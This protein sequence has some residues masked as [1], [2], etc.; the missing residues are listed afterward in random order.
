MRL[1]VIHT[2]QNKEAA[3]VAKAVAYFFTTRADGSSHYVVDDLEVYQCVDDWHE[4]CGAPGANHDGIHVEHAGMAGQTPEEWM[5][6]YSQA[7]LRNS[8]DLVRALCEIYEIP[9]VRLTVEQV[10]DGVSKGICG[11][12]DVSRAFGKSDHTDPGEHFPWDDY[13]RMVTGEP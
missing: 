4:A 3:G 11:H 12:V 9:P 7:E 5:D 2:T 10:R 1:I 8:A 6:L 13:I